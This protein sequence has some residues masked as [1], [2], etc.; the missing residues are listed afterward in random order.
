MNPCLG[1]GICGETC[2]RLRE[3][4]TCRMAF[5]AVGENP[6]LHTEQ[7]PKEPASSG[8]RSGASREPRRNEPGWFDLPP[9]ELDEPPLVEALTGCVPGWVSLNGA[10]GR[11]ARAATQGVLPMRLVELFRTSPGDRQGEMRVFVER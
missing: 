6:T 11:N 10:G 9:P 2:L 1:N 4:L 7:V 3:G 8:F 5:G